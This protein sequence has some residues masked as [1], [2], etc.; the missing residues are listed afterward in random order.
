[1]FISFAAK[2]L[3]VKTLSTSK[4]LSE[5]E[6]DHLIKTRKIDYGEIKSNEIHKYES[7]KDNML[8]LKAYKNDKTWD[9]V[10]L[11]AARC[12]NLN[13]LKILYNNQFDFNYTN[14][15]GKNALHEVSI[16]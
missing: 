3:F 15:D 7:P 2:M 13:L 5:I 9:N 12:E 4:D 1:M 11:Y 8:I 10:L 16:H 6:L 14:K